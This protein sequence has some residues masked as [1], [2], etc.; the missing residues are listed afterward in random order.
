MN[1]E[2]IS[3]TGYL[4]ERANQITIILIIAIILAVLFLTNI[5]TKKEIEKVTFEQ[6]AVFGKNMKNEFEMLI[7]NKKQSNAFIALSLSK[8]PI[9]TEALKKDDHNLINLEEFAR[10]IN[11]FTD[12]KNIWF[13]IIDKEGESFYRSWTRKRGDSLVDVRIDVRKMIQNPRVMSTISVGK[14]DMSFKSMVPV[15]NDKKEFIGMFEIISHFNSIVDKLEAENIQA[16]IVAHKK[17]K[18]QI[19]KPLSDTF[20]GDYYVSTVNTDGIVSNLIKKNG[21]DYYLSDNRFITDNWANIIEVTCK[22]VDIYGEDLGYALL[23]KSLKK[24]KNLKIDYIEHNIISLMIVFILISVI[25]GYYLINKRY[26]KNLIEQHKKHEEEIVKSTKFFTI[27]QMS[28]GITHEI[29]TPLTYIKGTNE[30]LKYDLEELPPSQLRDELLVGNQK[31]ANG[32]NRIGIIVESMREMAQ[33]TPAVKENSNIYSTL[34]T[35]LRMVY[36]RS[37]QITRIYLNG[38]LFNLEDSDKGKFVI[39]GM[40]NNQRIE[41]VW[42]IILNNALDEL[43]NIEPYENR[44]IKINIFK[45]NKKIKVTFLDN[46]GGISEN[47]KGKIFEPFISSKNYSGIGIGLNVAKKI[48]DEHNANIKAYNKKGGACFEVTFAQE[49]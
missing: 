8:N 29:N 5:I 21:V 27:G 36:N 7:E 43:V 35:V 9:I 45:E 10:L 11:E 40:I 32:I 16:L 4:S 13:Q 38:E 23:F 24:E 44:Y 18:K 47:I 20:I 26:E 19:V 39:T 34:V 6:N 22:I 25:I 33:T 42:T 1:E 12:Y 14:Y 17:Y 3:K 37:K 28:A 2:N 48:L 46:A 15:Y 30:M 41:Q 31:I 49:E